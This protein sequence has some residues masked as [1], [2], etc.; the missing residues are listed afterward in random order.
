MEGNTEAVPDSRCCDIISPPAGTSATL[1]LQIYVYFVF[2]W[3]FLCTQVSVDSIF[4]FLWLHDLLLDFTT[5]Q[6]RTDFS[7]FPP[8]IFLNLVHNVSEQTALKKSI[9]GLSN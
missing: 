2:V 4:C 7:L 9:P 3:V 8:R 5:Q 1:Q 6:G